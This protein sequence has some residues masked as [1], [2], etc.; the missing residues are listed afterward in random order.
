M[1]NKNNGYYG[2]MAGTFTAATLQ[3]FDNI[4]MGLIVPPQGLSL[5]RNF[6]TNVCLVTKYIHK[7]EGARAF[8]KGL[9]SNVWKTGLSSAIYFYCLRTIEQT[10]SGGDDSL[11]KK[12]LI[13]QFMSSC[14]ARITSA[15]LTNPLAVV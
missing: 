11:G 7:E 3:P 8:Y 14:L 4:K 10:L 2:L 6:I 5:T 13:T 15:I 9:V 1:S 12:N